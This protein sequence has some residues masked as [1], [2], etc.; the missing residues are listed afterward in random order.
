MVCLIDVVMTADRQAMLRCVRQ[1]AEVENQMTS[2]ERIMEYTN[3]ESE[4]SAEDATA[5]VDPAASWPSSGAFEFVN[6]SMQY[7]PLLPSA[8]IGAT[9]NVEDGE[10]VGVVGRYDA[11]CVLR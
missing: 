2:V 6:V 11:L 1:S 9:F 7:G 5:V 3:L 4:T 8:I 10:K